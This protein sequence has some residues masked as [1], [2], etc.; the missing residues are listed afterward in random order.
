MFRN[1]NIFSKLVISYLLLGIFTVIIVSVFFYHAFKTALIERTSAQLSSINMLKKAQIE[2]F[3]LNLA[4][5]DRDLFRQKRVMDKVQ[6][7][8]FIRTGMGNT[9]ESYLVGEDT[10]MLS[11]SRFFPDA[12][13]S[14]IKVNTSS[15]ILALAGY[16]GVHQTEDYRN[17]KY[18]VHTEN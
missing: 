6:E 9:G 1:I 2:S 10:T 18:S 7:I 17:V 13:P 11:R 4:D 5:K 8:L 16:E 14:D 15:A 12:K 3:L